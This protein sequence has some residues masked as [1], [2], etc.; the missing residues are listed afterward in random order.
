[1]DYTLIQK[2][3]TQIKPDIRLLDV[4]EQSRYNR[5]ISPQKQLEFLTGRTLLKTVLAD[6]AGVLPQSVSLTITASGKPYWSPLVNADMPFFNLSHADGRFVV[7]LSRYPVG[8]DIELVRPMKL[9]YMRPFL[10]IG[11]YKS[12]L[13]VPE[14]MRSV[15]FFRLF[16][17]KEAFLKA[18]DKRWALDDISF[19]LENQHWQL[20][21]PQGTFQFYGSESKD[22]F[23]TV[24]LDRSADNQ[25]RW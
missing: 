3:Q 24:C 21:T 19:I 13:N 15:L 18:T 17:A 1:M 25:W 11:E 5:L 6:Y 2:Q 9:E 16:T 14:S 22:C 12:L 8:I 7:A 4:V 23:I 10:S 20:G